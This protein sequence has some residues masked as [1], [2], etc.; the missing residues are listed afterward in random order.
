MR[1]TIDDQLD[2]ARRLLAGVERD[3]G[4]SAASRELLAHVHRL[5]TRVGGS[6]STT[7]PFLVEDNAATAALLA[8]LGVP[9]PP[10]DPATSDVAAA[11]ARNT[12]LRD[13]LA[14]AIRD[15]PR[16]AR[17]VAARARIGEHLRRRVAADPT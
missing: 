8:D 14:G 11:A 5:L 1:P 2:G 10:G 17:G 12:E 4:L 15:L 7:L 6:W 16:D 3:E 9:V 13:A